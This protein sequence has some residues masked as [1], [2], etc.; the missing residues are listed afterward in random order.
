MGDLFPSGQ[1]QEGESG[2]CDGGEALRKVLPMT[3]A[4]CPQEGA[5]DCT[6][7]A[8]WSRGGQG[9]TSIG[10]F[11]IFDNKGGKLRSKQET[12]LFWFALL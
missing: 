9:V 7:R 2:S 5:V 6:D 11:K 10:S 8:A 3:S 1:G 12:F 4:L